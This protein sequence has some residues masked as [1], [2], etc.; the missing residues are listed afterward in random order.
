MFVMK[1]FTKEQFW[2]YLEKEKEN[3]SRCAWIIWIM[4]NNW[5]M[6]LK[7]CFK[8]RLKPAWRQNYTWQNEWQISIITHIHQNMWTFIF[9]LPCIIR[10]FITERLVETFSMGPDIAISEFFCVD[11]VEL[12]HKAN[13]MML[14]WIRMIQ[15]QQ[16]TTH[17]F[18]GTVK[19]VFQY[20]IFRQC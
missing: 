14:L 13:W 3:S 2:H 16:I 19:A 4:D 18:N 11:S 20:S 10:S 8:T 17:W 5:S 9:H 7:T 15:L 12:V 6:K 1:T